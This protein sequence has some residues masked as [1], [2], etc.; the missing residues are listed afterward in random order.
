[1]RDVQEALMI[2]TAVPSLIRSGCTPDADIVYRTLVTAGPGT[3]PALRRD[4]EMAPARIDRAIDELVS[5]HA[6]VAHHSA[7]H[8]VTL[9]CARPPAEVV[10]GLHRRARGDLSR[11]RSAGDTPPVPVPALVD[12]GDGLRHLPTRAAT[13]Q[14]LQQLTSV[15]RTEHLAMHPE[16]A[17]DGE[18]THAALPMDRLLLNRGVRMRVLGVHS[19]D[20]DPL[21][22]CGRRQHELQPDYRQSAS[23]PMK[24]IVIDRTVAFFP[25]DPANLDRGYLEISQTPVVSALVAAFERQWQ[26]SW[27]AEEAAMRELTLNPQQRA[28]VALLADGHTDVT[29]A[30]ALGISARSVTKILRGLMDELEVDNR[31]QLGIALG[32]AR[33]VPPPRRASRNSEQGDG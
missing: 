1:M 22:I 30:R 8:A 25:V 26:Q 5:L 4:L 6:V 29:A 12:L 28:L 27:N 11:D 32:A 24:L 20:A 17:F 2:G 10:A 21:L 31:F 19:P 18:S 7:R 15:A 3:K 13:R 14:R 33:M 9:W 23:L 16:P